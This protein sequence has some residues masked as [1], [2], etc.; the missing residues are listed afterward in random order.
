MKPPKKL[1]E[2]RQ[3]CLLGKNSLYSSTEENRKDN[4]RK[5]LSPNGG[6]SYRKITQGRQ[7]Q[8]RGWLYTGAEE[9]NKNKAK[10][11]EHEKEKNK[12]KDNL[13]RGKRSHNI[14]AHGFQP[15]GNK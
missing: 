12:T 4:K 7:E 5:S 14:Q 8:R 2:I 9:E 6:A 10:T 1:V 11:K 13:F 3:R 15:S